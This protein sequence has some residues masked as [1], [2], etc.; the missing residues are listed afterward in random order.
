MKKRFFY[1]FFLVLTIQS[2]K[3]QIL[4]SVSGKIID[5]FSENHLVNVKVKLLKNIHKTNTDHNGNFRLEANTY[6][7]IYF[8]NISSRIFL[9]K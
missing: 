3:A 1:I 2:L 4:P 5:D 7:R 6:W 9:Q 8:R